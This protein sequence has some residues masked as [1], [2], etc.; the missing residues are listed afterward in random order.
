MVILDTVTRIG[1]DVVDLDVLVVHPAQ[2][3]S[4]VFVVGPDVLVDLP[5]QS[6]TD[7]L[8]VRTDVLFVHPAQSESLYPR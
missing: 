8:V 6:E 7:V 2:S 3:Q 4:V 1:P 5:D